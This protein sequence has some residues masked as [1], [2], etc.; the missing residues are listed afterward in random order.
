MPDSA[1]IST[2]HEPMPLDPPVTTATPLPLVM[3]GASLPELFNSR[4]TSNAVDFLLRHGAFVL[5]ESP[6]VIALGLVWS[7]REFAVMANKSIFTMMNG[8]EQFNELL[9][10][11]FTIFCFFWFSY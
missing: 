1:R 10:Y 2:E 3:Y 5:L 8:A 11:I 7:D 9:L 4:N 6:T